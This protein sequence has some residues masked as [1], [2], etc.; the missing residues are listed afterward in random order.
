MT[1]MLPQRGRIGQAAA[2]GDLGFYKW[3]TSGG[4]IAN[5]AV[6]FSLA[7]SGVAS[8]DVLIYGSCIDSIPF[9]PGSP[10]TG[11]TQLTLITGSVYCAINY[12]VMDGT[13]TTVDMN[14][15][16]GNSSYD[17]QSYVAYLFSGVASPV[18]FSTST[19]TTGNPDPPNLVSAVSGDLILA[20]GFL[21]DDNITTCTNSD[22]SNI[23]FAAGGGASGQTQSAMGGLCEASV[24]TDPA[25][26]STDGNDA[27]KAISIRIAPA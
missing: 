18:D 1:L 23:E 15:W 27:W 4:I 25:A 8:G 20:M 22:L 16:D 5:S 26:F 12:R 2:G 7:G 6:T 24:T 19:G 10:P 3:S 11:Y 21:D 9:A 14:I 13:E 17:N